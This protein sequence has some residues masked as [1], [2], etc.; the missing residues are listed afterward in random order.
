MGVFSACR[1]ALIWHGLRVADRWLGPIPG[2]S[3]GL[4]QGFTSW[5]SMRCI[6]DGPKAGPKVGRIQTELGRTYFLSPGAAAL[7]WR[8]RAIRETVRC[9]CEPAHHGLSRC[10][11]HILDIGG[12]DG[13]LV[14]GALP[15][16]W[17]GSYTLVESDPAAL[18]AA[19]LFESDAVRRP[20]LISTYLATQPDAKT[21]LPPAS[22][23]VIA[24][25]LELMDDESAIALLTEARSAMEARRSA[26]GGS[27]GL[28]CTTMIRHTH[29]NLVRRC[30]D[31]DRALGRPVTGPYFRTT[32]VMNRLLNRAG[33]RAETLWRCEP[34]GLVAVGFQWCSGGR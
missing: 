1:D 12:G 5:A 22:L 26:E 11:P 7:R 28:L 34:N 18:T 19:E 15:A 25:V 23:V 6:L 24:G 21:A 4:H 14:R 16:N 27:A 13:S 31:H 20:R 17:R 29:A 2:I 10:S 9:W 3:V 30:I 8:C 32:E 33:F